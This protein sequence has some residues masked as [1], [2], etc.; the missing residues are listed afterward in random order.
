MRRGSAQ[1]G[2]GKRLVVVDAGA[3]FL[4]TVRALVVAAVAPLRCIARALT[5]EASRAGKAHGVRASHTVSATPAGIGAS[6]VGAS[7]IGASGIGAAA[8]QNGVVEA[9]SAGSRR[10]VREGAV[11]PA[12]FFVGVGQVDPKSEPTTGRGQ[13]GSRAKQECPA[14]Q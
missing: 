7:G 2:S 10:E 13:G 4:C 1:R 5:V 9:R 8:G 12:R 14:F 11:V 3:P 6:G